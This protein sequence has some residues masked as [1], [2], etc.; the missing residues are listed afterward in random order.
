MSDVPLPSGSQHIV[1]YVYYEDPRAATEY[2][3]Q[4]F[5]FEQ[6]ARMMGR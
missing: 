6:L 4:V 5:G 1:P 2:P 3:C